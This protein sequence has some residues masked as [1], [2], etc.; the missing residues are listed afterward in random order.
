[1]PQTR[2]TAGINVSSYDTT[3]SLKYTVF[4]C[5]ALH[6]YVHIDSTELTKNSNNAQVIGEHDPLYIT[7]QGT[8][9]SYKN[10]KEILYAITWS[11]LGTEWTTQ[12]KNRHSKAP[13]CCIVLA[14]TNCSFLPF[15]LVLFFLLSPQP[16]CWGWCW[17][18]LIATAVVGLR[19]GLGIQ[20]P[21]T[22]S[23]IIRRVHNIHR[24][25]LFLRVWVS[26]TCW[27]LW[28]VEVCGNI[29]PNA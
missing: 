16:L 9:A 27:L 8:Q 11:T 5:T 14:L 20:L 26:I 29:I 21:Y 24:S 10:R 2:S 13:S 18:I 1:M 17:R 4:H 28:R 3:S 7:V 15:P 19:L 22:C 23:Y 12:V 6:Y 25:L